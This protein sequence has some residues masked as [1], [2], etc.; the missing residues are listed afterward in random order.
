MKRLWLIPLICVVIVIPPAVVLA[1][2]GGGGFD[3]VRRGA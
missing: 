3:G 1:S 2:N